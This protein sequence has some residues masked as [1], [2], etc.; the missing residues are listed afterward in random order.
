MG[1]FLALQ[2]T[3]LGAVSCGVRNLVQESSPYNVSRTKGPKGLLGNHTG[4][5]EP[6]SLAAVS[7]FSQ[8]LDKQ[9][10]SLLFFG[11]INATVTCVG[12]ARNDIIS[13]DDYTGVDV[14]GT[15]IPAMQP[16]ICSFD[17]SSDDNA[18][19][20]DGFCQVTV[21]LTDVV[22]VSMNQTA[23]E[24]PGQDSNLSSCNSTM[25]DILTQCIKNPQFSGGSAI[26]DNVF[27]QILL[28]QYLPVKDPVISANPTAIAFPVEDEDGDASPNFSSALASTSTAPTAASSTPTK[29]TITNCPSACAGA[30]RFCCNSGSNLDNCLT[31]LS[32]AGVGANQGACGETDDQNLSDCSSTCG[33][34][35]GQGSDTPDLT[36]T[37]AQVIFQN[38]QAAFG[39]P[40]TEVTR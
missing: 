20:T 11:H 28:S 39:F 3:L 9:L 1:G 19:C 31:Q 35:P 36:G 17:T 22:N 30:I 6:P 2:E 18:F 21:A 33:L 12:P 32:G 25:N 14:E 38:I 23:G 24:N 37:Q 29:P 40:G 8:I 5:A 10:V 7:C 13:D 16:I 15:V 4:N 26:V 34:G 27:R